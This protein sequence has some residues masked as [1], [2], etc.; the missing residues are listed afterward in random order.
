M[1]LKIN[2]NI[3]GIFVVVLTSLSLITALASIRYLSSAQVFAV[4]IE[5]QYS[6]KSNW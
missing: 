3:I 1:I 5:H 4:T 6:T 2:S